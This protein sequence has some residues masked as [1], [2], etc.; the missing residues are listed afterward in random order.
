MV[1]APAI[2][3]R[4]TSIIELL[5]EIIV[6]ANYF[7]NRVIREG[8]S[9][10][11]RKVISLLK[12]ISY[13]FRSFSTRLEEFKDFFPEFKDDI[14]KIQNHCNEVPNLATKRMSLGIER[15]RSKLATIRQE[16]NNLYDSMNVYAQEY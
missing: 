1:K 4:F 10:D 15:L 8:H 16:S 12:L 6:R 13:S 11:T 7:E 5:Q 14:E 9:D 2:E 3:K